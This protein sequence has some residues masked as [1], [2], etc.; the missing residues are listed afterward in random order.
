MYACGVAVE[1]QVARRDR[2]YAWTQHS[3]DP[4]VKYRLQMLPVEAVKMGST[5][6]VCFY[7]SITH[8]SAE[9]KEQVLF[10]FMLGGGR[11][12]QLTPCAWKLFKQR[13]G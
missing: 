11:R 13:K 3:R 4:V 10:V 12:R 5:C 2:Q 8:L 7:I 6:V 1:S 9:E